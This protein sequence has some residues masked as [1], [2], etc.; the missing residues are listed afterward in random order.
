ML[1][2][3]SPRPAAAS[4][5]KTVLFVPTYLLIVFAALELVARVLVPAPEA[6]ALVQR[7]H[8]DIIEILGLP[9]L[10]DAMRPDPDLFWALRPGFSAMV[11]GRIREHP[12]S[13]R[14]TVNP[15]GLRGE[16]IPAK[17][18][19]FRVLAVGDSSTFGVGVDDG[20][21]WPAQLETVM[22]TNRRRVEVVN[23]GVPGYTAFQGLRF[24]R[25]P[26]VALQPDLV[27][28]AFGFNDADSTWASRSDAET[29][30]R[31]ASR[32][33]DAP[34]MQSRLYSGLKLLALW[35]R[36][37][38]LPPEGPG[39]PRLSPDEFT[40]TLAQMSE[41]ATRAGARF[42]LVIWPYAS[43][44][45]ATQTALTGY[46]PLVAQVAKERGVPTAN[47]IPAFVA[48]GRS[49]FVDHVHANADGCRLAADTIA[50][51]IAPLVTR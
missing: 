6:K 13:F 30:R 48:D 26:G 49:L 50:Q 33:W 35:V 15:Q 7:E 10:N 29:A 4:R 28:A 32:G 27:V 34:L 31:L 51:T 42:A 43:Q 38:E 3:T 9:A 40:D 18:D 19:A 41:T 2:T 17:G 44:V 8:Q 39:R 14:V 45:A 22:N 21:T 47:L 23:A 11:D 5:L 24:L 46:Q 1:D 36:P 20:A 37:P 12:V 16:P 25:G